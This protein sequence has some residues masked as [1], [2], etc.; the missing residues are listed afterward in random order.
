MGVALL[1]ACGGSSGETAAGSRAERLWVVNAAALI[2]DLQ[3]DILLSTRGGDDVASARRAMQTE[4]DVYLLLVAY[5]LFG[6]CGQKVEQLGTPNAR[7][8][9]VRRT[10][11]AACR[12]LERSASLFTRAMTGSQ[13]AALVAATQ[14]ALRVTPL[15]ER[16]KSE[17]AAVGGESG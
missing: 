15:L 10:L 7:L 13:P 16:A 8:Q 2:G 4:G 3:A 17:L 11:A 12:H 6:D 5:G 1:T 9:Q 14:T